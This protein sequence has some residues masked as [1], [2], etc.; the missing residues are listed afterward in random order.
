MPRYRPGFSDADY[1]RLKAAM[2]Q[3]GERGPFTA[4]DALWHVFDAGVT[5]NAGDVSAILGDLTDL[6]YLRALGGDPLRWELA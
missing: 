1:D 4:S 6:G 5:N 3:V 2:Q